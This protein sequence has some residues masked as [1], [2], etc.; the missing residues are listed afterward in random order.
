MDSEIRD[1]DLFSSLT[2]KLI[3]TFNDLIKRAEKYITL[4]EVRKAKKTES[5]PSVSEKNKAPEVKPA[6][7]EPVRGRFHRKIEKYTSLKLQPTEVL[8][9]VVDHLEMNFVVSITIMDTTPM[10]AFT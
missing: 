8:Q 3:A 4:E 1:G 9:V 6:D 2:K 7:P 5:K 10:I